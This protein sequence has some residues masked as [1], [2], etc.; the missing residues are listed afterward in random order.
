MS[1]EVLEAGAPPSR[2]GVPAW[3]VWAIGG[4][5]LAVITLG[6]VLAIGDLAARTVTMD[7]L[8]SQVESSESAMKAAQDEFASTIEPYSAGDMTDADREKL[9]AD[10]ADAAARG[11]DAIAAAGV[12]VG[13]VT[14][15]PWQGNVAEARDAY[16]RHNAA[17]VAYLD[18]ASQDPDEWFRDQPE[19]NSTFYDARVPLVEAVTL[20]D[21]TNAIER[22]KVIYAD[23]D[24]SNGGGQSA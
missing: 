5:V 19:V 4:V 16:L 8:L 1:Q 15:L 11:R 21:F 18:A 7:R 10:L 24:E 3:V 2:D 13:A 12:G 23:S 6:Y 9:R 22:I 20:F 17:W 14:V